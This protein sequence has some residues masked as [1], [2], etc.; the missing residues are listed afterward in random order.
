MDH[1]PFYESIEEQPLSWSYLVPV[2]VSDL[3][4]LLVGPLARVNMGF[5]TETPWAEMECTRTHEQWGHP[6]D[7]ELLFL[8]AMTLEVIW[9]YEKACL[10]LEQRPRVGEAFC[11]PEL[12]ECEGLAVIDGPRGT[13]VHHVRVDSNG[14]VDRYRVISPL[15]FN[16]RMLNQHLTAFTRHQVR[17]IDIGEE[18]AEQLQLVVRTFSPCVPCGTH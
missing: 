2:T 13:L 16:Y 11:M 18:V 17:G 10:L 1:Q 14:D 7:R 12:G 9:A 8:L 6:L 15:Q 5:D 3:Q 4:P